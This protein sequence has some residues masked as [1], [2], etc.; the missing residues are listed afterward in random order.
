MIDRPCDFACPH[1][2]MGRDWSKK[3]LTEVPVCRIGNMITTVLNIND[4]G[5]P[6]RQSGCVRNDEGGETECQAGNTLEQG[7]DLSP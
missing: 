5:L 3:R 6:C 7:W 4:I 2:Q 1:L